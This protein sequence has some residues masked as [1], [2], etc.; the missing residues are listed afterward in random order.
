MDVFVVVLILVACE[1]F[2]IVLIG[3]GN[4]KFNTETDS[5]EDSSSEV[6]PTPS[7]PGDEKTNSCLVV[8][9]VFFVILIGL[10]IFAYAAISAVGEA[11]DSFFGGVND[12]SDAV[13]SVFKG[14]KSSALSPGGIFHLNRWQVRIF[15]SASRRFSGFR[16]ETVTREEVEQ[17][18][19]AQK[20]AILQGLTVSLR[21]AP[22]AVEPLKAVVEELEKVH[23]RGVALT[24]QGHGKHRVGRIKSVSVGV[25]VGY[26]PPCPSGNASDETGHADI[27][28]VVARFRDTVFDLT[29]A[30]AD[31][32]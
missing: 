22:D 28:S 4:E 29:P 23:H 14:A 26:T 25:N 8:L 16:P 21:N 30:T 18:L 32:P 19:E 5:T 3:K 7:P 24:A 1:I 6:T 12:F 20:T 11:L 15:K 2:F 13:E 31:T 9:V 17:L 10:G 27:E